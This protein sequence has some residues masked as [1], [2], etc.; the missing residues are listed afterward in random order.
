MSQRVIINALL[1][2]ADCMASFGNILGDIRMHSDV[3]QFV[4][5]ASV[6]RKCNAVADALAKKAKSVRGVQ[7]WLADLPADIAPL[8]LY[9]V[10]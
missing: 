8:L 2:G 4:E 1:H 6:N 3:F 7:V 9:D 5:F 10:H